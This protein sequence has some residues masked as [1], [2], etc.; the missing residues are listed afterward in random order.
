MTGIQTPPTG[1]QRNKTL[2][3]KPHIASDFV[4]IW[5]CYPTILMGNILRSEYYPTILMDN[6]L[7]SEYYPTIL[8]DNI[9]RS[10]YYPAILMDNFSKPKSFPS[11]LKENISHSEYF[12]SF[13][14]EK[15]SLSKQKDPFCTW[16]ESQVHNSNC[17]PPSVRFW[18][19]IYFSLV[20]TD[21]SSDRWQLGFWQHRSWHHI[22]QIV[23]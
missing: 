2:Q 23:Y 17:H 18:G 13:L 16:T 19:I 3:D 20:L 4:S 12:P 6:I 14:M 7:R 8:M 9:L 1:A 11:F 5:K 15:I 22:N 21:G 10:E